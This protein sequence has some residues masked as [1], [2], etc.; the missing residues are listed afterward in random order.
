MSPTVTRLDRLDRDISVAHVALGV[1]RAAYTRCPSAE[2]AR[3]V[4]EAWAAVDRLLD[5]RLAAQR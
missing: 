3:L 5:E 4:E 2:N 1:A